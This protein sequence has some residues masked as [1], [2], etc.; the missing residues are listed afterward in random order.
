MLELRGKYGEALPLYREA[1]TTKTEVLGEGHRDLLAPLNNLGFALLYTGTTDEAIVL[2]RRALDMAEYMP[3]S[4]GNLATVRRNLSDALCTSG[5]AQEGPVLAAAAVSHFGLEDPASW[6]L[7]DAQS[8]LGGCLMALGDLQ[9]A[10]RTLRGAVLDLERG[11]SA[12]EQQRAAQARRR[13]D[14]F[15]DLVGAD[16]EV[17][18]VATPDRP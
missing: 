4:K 2:L 18:E 1:L 9:G 12:R 15:L 16:L 5:Q 8:V 6:Q 14:A 10:G 13:Y 3:A 11:T 17:P 7:A